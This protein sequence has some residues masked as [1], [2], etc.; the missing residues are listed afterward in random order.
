MF[1]FT[2]GA[3]EIETKIREKLLANSNEADLSGEFED[4]EFED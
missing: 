2:V 3:D 1:F 4:E